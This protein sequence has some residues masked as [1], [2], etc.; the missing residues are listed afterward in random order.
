MTRSLELVSNISLTHIPDD[1][2]DVFSSTRVGT[3]PG[4]DVHLTLM[5]D[6]KPSIKPARTIP[7]SLK[8]KV[9]EQLDTLESRG[10]IAKSPYLLTGSTKWL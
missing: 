10:I 7:E 4:S 3:L 1:Y 6:A 9:K 2:L 5:D 8:A